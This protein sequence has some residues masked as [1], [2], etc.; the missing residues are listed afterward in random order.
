[1]TSLRYRAMRGYQRARIARARLLGSRRAW[2]GV[3]VLGYHRVAEGSTSLGVSPAA[4]REQMEIVRGSGAELI[5]LEDAL[6]LLALGRVEGRYIAVT[7]DDGYADN[8]ESAEPVLAELGIPATIFL[9]TRVIDGTTPYYWF[10]DRPRALTW[11]EVRDAVRRGTFDF[12]SHTRTHPW[13]P[14]LSDAQARDEIFGSREDIADRIGTVPSSLCYPGGLYSARDER[15]VTEAG[16]RA[17]VTTIP[18]VNTGGETAIRRTLI[19]G[20][21]STP[22]FRTKLAGLLDRPGVGRRIGYRRLGGFARG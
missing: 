14:D 1:M 22:D 16:Y 2:H 20:E 6:D 5:R 3:R 12:Q 13:L 17:A 15:L 10:P 11:E 9:P 19:Y 18:G 4:F 7:F 21:D 8:V